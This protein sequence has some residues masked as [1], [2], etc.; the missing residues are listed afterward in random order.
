MTA[1]PEIR[2]LAPSDLPEIARV[3]LAA[4]RTSALTSLGEEALRRYYAWLLTGPHDAAALGAFVGDRC[5]G[6]C[7]GGVFSGALSGYLAANRG[8][9]VRRVLTRPWLLASPLVRERARI[10]LR[11]LLRRRRRPAAPAEPRTPSFGVLALA[12]DPGLQR[13]GAGRLLMDSCDRIARE[14]GFAEMDLTVH[15]ENLAG[16]RFYEALGWRR[17]AGPSGWK[18]EMRKTLAG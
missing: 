18:G 2:R 10:A 12:V 7:V 13:T 3:H 8:Y 16:V 11:L 17:V 6:F 14:R 5:V 1:A 4:F 9:L 15:P